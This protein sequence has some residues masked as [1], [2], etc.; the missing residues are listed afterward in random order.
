MTAPPE[1]EESYGP[2]MRA[3]TPKQRAFVIQYI[4]N[5]LMSAST[6]AKLAGYANV[7]STVRVKT[8]ENLRKEKIIRAINEELDKRFRT[9]AIVGHAVLIE[10]ALDKDHPKR[11]QAAEALLSRGCFHVLHEQRVRVEHVDMT[12]EAMVERITKLAQR[13][14]M[15]PV[16][17]L[18]NDP[19]A[20][21]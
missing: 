7:G 21:G 1:D 12:S 20:A 15:D 10:I 9:S 13:L 18:G 19:N 5:P 14:D 8:F 4:E 2:A 6:A 11:L 17:L 3:L 16:L